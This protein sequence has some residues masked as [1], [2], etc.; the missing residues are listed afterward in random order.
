MGISDRLAHAWNAFM[1]RDPTPEY[2]GYR[3]IGMSY[4]I[5]IGRASC[6]ERVCLYV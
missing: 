4:P 3:D 6:R 5:K 2:R 1:N